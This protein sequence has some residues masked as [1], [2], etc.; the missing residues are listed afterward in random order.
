MQDVHTRIRLFAPSDRKETTKTPSCDPSAG[1]SGLDKVF[2][3]SCLDDFAR[4]DARR[5]HANTLVRPFNLGLHRAQVDVPAPACGVVGVGDIVT[6]LRPFAAKI[7]FGCHGDAPIFLTAEAQRGP[8]DRQATIDA[9]ERRVAIP[10]GVFTSCRRNGTL[11]LY[12]HTTPGPKR[13]IMSGD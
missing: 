5:A 11:A 7:T 4:L 1:A 10:A 8:F 2:G 9:A 12:K 13:R 6:E 3:L